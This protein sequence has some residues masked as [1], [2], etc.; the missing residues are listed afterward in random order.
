L[1][2]QAFG[3]KIPKPSEKSVDYFKTLVPDD[4]RIS[5]RP[6]FGN[7]AAFVNGNLFMG[8]YGDDIFV[9]L[10]EEDQPELLDLR[11]ASRFE[12]VAGR[13]MKDYIVLPRTLLADPEKSA[14][15]VTRSLEWALT[16][17]L[18]EHKKKGRTKSGQKLRKR[19]LEQG[20]VVRQVIN[21]FKFSYNDGRDRASHGLC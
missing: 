11:G 8:L 20:R 15:W 18:K 4:Y 9:R 16:L 12:P 21:S 5:L 10:S 6:M 13:V 2:P 14:E 17:P 19:K 7:L 3:L 1:E